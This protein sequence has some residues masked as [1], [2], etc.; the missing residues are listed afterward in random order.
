MYSLYEEVLQF[1][2]LNKFGLLHL[3]SELFDSNAVKLLCKLIFNIIKACLLSKK[4]SSI[5][6]NQHVS[7]RG[8][9]K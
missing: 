7:V 3:Y 6:E 1:L 9:N 8:D 4:G 2:V 5:K